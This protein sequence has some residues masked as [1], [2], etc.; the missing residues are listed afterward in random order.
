MALWACTDASF[1]SRPKSG[2]VAVGLETPHPTSS[3]PPKKATD[4]VPRLNKPLFA[5]PAFFNHTLSSPHP[6]LSL[7]TLPSMSTASAY[8]WW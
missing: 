7:T 5:L 4:R 2:S 3:T 8:P 6:P 1:L